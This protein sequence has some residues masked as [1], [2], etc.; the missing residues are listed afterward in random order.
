M[1][2]QLLDILQEENDFGVKIGR[3][4]RS[5]RTLFSS[6]ELQDKIKYIGLKG[7]YGS[8]DTK[9]FIDWCKEE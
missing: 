9:V 2:Y 8:P 3:G 4:V 7:G 5:I 1:I 6:L